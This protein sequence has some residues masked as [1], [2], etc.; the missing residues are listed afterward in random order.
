LFPPIPGRTKKPD[1]KKMYT[2]RARA[3]LSTW[4]ATG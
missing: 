1:R 2:D 4:L 3:A